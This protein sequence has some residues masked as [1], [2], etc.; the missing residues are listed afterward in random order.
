VI[1]PGSLRFQI[2]A[3]LLSLLALFA[4]T[5][6]YT[7]NALEQQ[8]NA[9]MVL[10]RAGRLELAGEQLAMQAMNYQENPP[11]DYE[12][13]HRDVR[14]YYR[15][16]LAHLNTFD[17]ILM[18]FSYQEFDAKL[19]GM[20]KTLHTDLTPPVREAVSSTVDLWMGYRR[21]L[22]EKLGEDEREPRLERGA[23]YIVDH[24]SELRDS[25]L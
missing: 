12:T 1:S 2:S 10:N 7:V 16:L 21:D 9:T 22:Q 8:R 4:G 25:T 14:L 15:D 3:A 20:Q 11:R 19:T 13:Y 5:V 6:T 17:E 24:H 18:A 23:E